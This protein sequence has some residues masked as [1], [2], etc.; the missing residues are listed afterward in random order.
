MPLP[1]SHDIGYAADT[2]IRAG[3]GV[4][5]CKSHFHS[6]HRHHHSADHRARPSHDG[7]EPS[8]RS[9]GELWRVQAGD[10]QLGYTTNWEST[11]CVP[12]RRLDRSQKIFAKW[13][14]ACSRL[15]IPTFCA[16]VR[17]L[18]D[19]PEF[20]VEMPR[21]ASNGGADALRRRP[22]NTGTPSPVFSF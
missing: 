20:S 4:G 6:N 22:Q 9:I 13:S 14:L 11:A 15:A 7:Q 10:Q 2:P 18:V 8:A 5:S 19:H 17:W 3:A 1:N 12:G 21:I 16:Q